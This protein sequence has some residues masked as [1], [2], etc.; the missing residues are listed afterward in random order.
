MQLL[1]AEMKNGK[2]NIGYDC[3]HV[4]WDCIAI[5]VAR[6]RLKTDCVGVEGEVDAF[7]AIAQCWALLELN[8]FILN[9]EV[10]P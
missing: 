9:L 4:M 2:R 3:D 10:L 7:H 6:L 8:M 5:L 1:F